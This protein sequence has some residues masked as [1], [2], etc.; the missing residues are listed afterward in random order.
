M[1][2][3]GSENVNDD[4]N[5]FDLLIDDQGIVSVQGADP[6]EPGEKRRVFR[7][8]SSAP[9]PSAVPSAREVARALAPELRKILRP[10]QVPPDDAYVDQDAGLFPR[11]VYLRLAR[12]GYFPVRKEGNFR[13]ARWADVKA[14]FAK[15]GRTDI[16]I[17]TQ[18]DDPEADLLN[19]IRQRAGLQVKGGR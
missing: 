3:M 7:V 15:A 11:E 5:R 4:E 13:F 16:T 2:G 6:R 8:G 14:G 18:T 19:A 10:T 17:V 12:K 9:S 1:A